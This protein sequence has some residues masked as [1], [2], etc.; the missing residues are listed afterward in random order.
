MINADMPPCTEALPPCVIV[1][2]LDGGKWEYVTGIT[3][4]LKP[5]HEACFV[6]VN[7][8]GYLI[9]GRGQHDPVDVFDPMTKTWTQRAGYGEKIHHMQCVAH[10]GKVWIPSSW[11]DNYPYEKNHNQI[12]IYD[13][14]QDNWS[15]LPGMREDR[16]RGGAASVLHDGKIY[17]VGG[18]RGGHGAHAETLGY[19]DYY[20]LSSEQW[21]MEL[22]E[23]PEPRDHVGGAMVNGRLCIAG[24]RNSGVSNFFNA[25]VASVW[26][27]DFGEMIWDR[28]DD[29][30]VPRAGAATATVCDGRL[31]IAGGETGRT[32][33]WERVDLFDG[34]NWTR[35][36]DLRRGRHGSGLGVSDC[37][38]GQVFV[39][40]GS[41]NKGGSPELNST[42][43]YTPSGG[44]ETCVVF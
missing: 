37:S 29:L 27:F 7:G 21:V 40:S 4:S 42:E 3:G 30:E 15:T 23:L 33:A 25:A 35:A 1:E 44:V 38:C 10:D 39:S 28:G 24:G 26:C 41:G 16:L 17:V 6:F 14:V 11:T 31:M 34:N 22:P 9:G 43:V 12:I 32:T 36:P 19:M 18:N 20:D 8:K 2:V 5:R 13:T